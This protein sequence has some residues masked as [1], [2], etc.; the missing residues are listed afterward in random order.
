MKI[1]YLQHVPYEGLGF[2]ETWLHI[3]KHDVSG[4]HFF[5]PDHQ[6]PEVAEL[7]ALIILGGPMNVNEE[8]AYPW[9]QVEKQFIQECIKS[10]KKVFGICLGA[11][12]IATALGASVSRATSKEIGWFR[13]VPTKES[14]QL[15]WFYELFKKKP[16]VFH[17]HYDRFDTPE[18]A[19]D[20]LYSPANLNQAFYLNENVMAIQFH[21]EITNDCL[22]Q[23]LIH[24]ASDL[25]TR[26]YVQTAEEVRRGRVNIGN[27]HTILSVILD[28]W[29]QAEKKKSKNKQ[30]QLS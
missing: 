7:D 19:V 16:V 27:C 3:N 4:T 5:D 18:N 23:F 17:W 25:D 13:V 2:I 21:L 22:E 29:L 26:Y 8:E 28:R 15:I 14:Q 6:L 24:G 11:Q 20:M 1:H 10:G 30:V 9:L 12:L